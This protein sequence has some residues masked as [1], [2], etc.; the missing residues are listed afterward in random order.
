MPK[1]SVICPTIGRP[2]LDEALASVNDAD[3]IIVVRDDLE[4]R[5]EQVAV[6][7]E[8]F[9]KA[10][11]DILIYLGERMV[12]APDW[13]QRTIDGFARIGN[14]GI[15]SYWTNIVI[16]GAVSRDYFEEDLE[17]CWYWPDY[18]HYCGD[19]ELGDRAR[20]DLSYVE[21]LGVIV[22]HYDKDFSKRDYSKNC[23]P[24]DEQ[25]YRLRTNAGWPNERLILDEE[26]WKHL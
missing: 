4:N 13:K 26:K 17:R 15:V 12:F 1:L 7:N 5:R 24:F 22:R 10:T 21:E 9:Q 14:S 3:E 18:L 11:G 8:G 25:T 20:R 19:I 6:V 2:S 23:G 16:A